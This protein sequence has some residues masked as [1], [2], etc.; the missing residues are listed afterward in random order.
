MLALLLK[1]DD[2]I[3]AIPARSVLEVVPKVALRPAPEAA[4]W[5]AGLFAYRGSILPA[6][7]LCMRV[8]GRPCR[9]LLSSRIVV[10]R[11]GPGGSGGSYGVLSENVTDV[12]D[13]AASELVHVEA[14]M[15]SYVKGTILSEG[16]MIHVLDVNCIL[17]ERLAL[18]AP[19]SIE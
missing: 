10:V 3:F 1:L 14:E 9:S 8:E 12:R 6:V 16:K 17:P 19:E 13:F 4:A 15:A 2:R 5:L 11:R 18:S 7:D